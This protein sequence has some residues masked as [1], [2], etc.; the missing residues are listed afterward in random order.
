MSSFPDR[1]FVRLAFLVIFFLTGFV[2]ASEEEET[3]AF[4]KDL[5]FHNFLRGVPEV[6]DINPDSKIFI[7]YNTEDSEHSA[8]VEKFC[9][10]LLLSGISYSNILFE[11]WFLR[12]GS[13]L[14]RHQYS[15]TILQ[16]DK[17]VV[18]G[19]PGLKKAY[20]SG[21]GWCY[22]QLTGL[23]SRLREKSG[24][25]VIFTHLDGTLES[26]FPQFTFSQYVNC[27]LRE[28]YGGPFFDFLGYLYQLPHHS[29]LNGLKEDFLR[30]VSQIP[31]DSIAAEGALR[32]R[33]REE[34]EASDARKREAIFRS[35]RGERESIF[36][37]SSVRFWGSASRA[38]TT[39]GQRAIKIV[40]PTDGDLGKLWRKKTHNEKRPRVVILG[41]GITG[42]LSAAQLASLRNETGDSLFEI[43]L[44]E[45]EP[46]LMNAASKMICRLHLGNE[47]PNH[48]ETAEQCLFGATL[49]RQQLQTDTILTGIPFNDFLIARQTL[50]SSELTRERLWEH[51]VMLQAAYARYLEQVRGRYN[52]AENLLFGPADT[53]FEALEEDQ[54]PEYFGYGIRTKERGI[55]PVALGTVLEGLLARFANIHVHC[56]TEIKA[57]ERLAG[58][59]F[60]LR[61]GS[62]KSF[63]S[64][65]LVNATWHNIHT[66]N[67]LLQAP[68]VPQVGPGVRTQV[69]LRTLLVADT[70]ECQFPA[71]NNS[72]FGLL[73]K[74]GG[75]FSRFNPR[76]A[77]IF[78]PADGYSYQGDC[79]LNEREVSASALPSELKERYQRLN[80]PVGR[81]MLASTI[82]NRGDQNIGA[83]AKYIPL[84]RARPLTSI[85]RTTLSQSDNLTQR[86]HIPVEWV[87]GVD[88]CIQA[89][90]AKG[91][92]A[93][94]TALQVVAHFLNGT[95]EGRDFANVSLQGRAFLNG[96]V[97]DRMMDN[98]LLPDE[99][100]LI[101]PNDP[102]A[103]PTQNAMRL[104]AFHRDIPFTV[105]EDS[106]GI[107][108][109]E[110][111]AL[112]DWQRAI[113]LEH[114][115]LSAG[116][117]EPVISSLRTATAVKLGIIDPQIE[118]MEDRRALMERVLNNLSEPEGFSVKGDGW[119]SCRALRQI[120]PRVRDFSARESHFDFMMIRENLFAN[121]AAMNT[122]T[123]VSF[124]SCYPDEHT[125]EALFSVLPRLS[126]L[127]VLD[128]SSNAIGNR[129]QN[130]E[131]RIESLIG[132]L[133]GIK[134]LF[135]RNNEF[136][137]GVRR[138]D[139]LH[140]YQ[141][142]EEP[143]VR[144]ILGQIER[145]RTLEHADFSQNGEP[146][147]AIQEVLDAYFMNKA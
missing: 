78:I 80:S 139:D 40:P 84:E 92:F 83:K 135:L 22:G 106:N 58:G 93:P 118:N 35:A 10:Q 59:G 42:V 19:S 130:P 47:Y 34:Q 65:Y 24:R 5:I 71:N 4:L 114:H 63:Y 30:I 46:V 82:L 146:S 44:I 41:G 134:R 81:E 67:H 136:F 91:T 69:F 123:R 73:N 39:S 43:D 79:V 86:A 25:N 70:T 11:R 107:S 1:L 56:A 137:Q 23:L 14:N 38:Q 111:L 54:I 33:E 128:L 98:G 122:L 26:C 120:M 97:S 85:T 143:T 76:A 110:Q 72:Y 89:S 108:P 126:Q 87:Q 142:I 102:I 49:F 7:L 125:L 51:N 2:N 15:D 133:S 50:D 61:T 115:I 57:V 144:G 27:D 140:R 105:F 119:L 127:E 121:T 6:V 18:I 3:R 60:G 32:R 101:R 90:S 31:E 132:Q 94:F 103:N 124:V 64:K 53:L 68:G 9:E 138:L 62:G 95:Q 36:R 45:S 20:E 109:E 99:F 74:Y 8:K 88:G 29:R 116:M 147:I 17:V 75:M 104:Y 13:G 21:I 96:L 48:R 129:L 113:D 117:V 37:D 145:S 28:S 66:F 77:A 12:P 112:V 55:Q 131:T 16:A 141:V 52:T 100:V